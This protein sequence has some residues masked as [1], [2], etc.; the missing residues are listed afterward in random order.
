[1]NAVKAEWHILVPHILAQRR[2]SRQ[3]RGRVRAPGNR[4]KV[5]SSRF[6]L[7]QYGVKVGFKRDHW[8]YY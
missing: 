7:F 1:M 5:H 4:G 3:H 2:Q 6:K 8:F